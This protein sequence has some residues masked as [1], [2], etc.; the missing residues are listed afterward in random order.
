MRCSF[1]ATGKGG[2]ARNLSP[3]EI[4]DQVLAV[5]E[6]MGQRVTNVVFMGMGEVS[7]CV[8]GGGEVMGQRITDVVF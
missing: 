3:H 1:C 4:M 8:G 6:V 2:F 7:V 5:G